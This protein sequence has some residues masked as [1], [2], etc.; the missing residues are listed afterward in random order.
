MKKGKTRDDFSSTVKLIIAQRAGYR[1]SYPDCSCGTIGPAVDSQK[2][3]NVGEACHICAASPGGPRY[4]P[5]MTSEQRMSAD[6]GIWMCRLHAAEIDRDVNRYTVE[7]LRKWKKIA[8]EKADFFRTNQSAPI[9]FLIDES[10]RSHNIFIEHGHLYRRLLIGLYIM[11]FGLIPLIR[12]IHIIESLSLLD[13]IVVFILI[14]GVGI[15]ML[16]RIE[17]EPTVAS[18]FNGTI[19]ENELLTNTPQELMSKVIGAFGESV[20]L[21]FDEKHGDFIEFYRFKRMSFGGWEKGK[22]NYLTIS[23]KFKLEYYDPSVLYLHAL[24]TRNTAVRLLSRQGFILQNKER[25]I[26]EWTCF[27]KGCLYVYVFY[28]KNGFIKQVVIINCSDD[29]IDERVTKYVKNDLSN[30]G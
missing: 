8:E 13:R 28:K 5:N 11:L 18:K 10:A 9:S 27:K 12:K 19:C 22:I 2:A 30:F 3:V 24:S 23:F 16:W 17:T 6:N 1:C 14:S 15:W 26:T 20:L 29:E 25:S 4:D 7:L 21:S